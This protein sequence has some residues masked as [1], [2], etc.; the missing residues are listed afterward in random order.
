[1]VGMTVVTGR[2][3]ISKVWTIFQAEAPS[4][5]WSW[6]VRDCQTYQLLR[7]ESEVPSYREAATVRQILFLRHGRDGSERYIRYIKPFRMT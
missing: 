5:T 3:R 1:M 4:Q 7:G 6:V 2:M